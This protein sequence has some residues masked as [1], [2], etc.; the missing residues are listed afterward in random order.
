MWPNTLNEKRPALI[1]T[2]LI[3]LL[4]QLADE[5]LAAS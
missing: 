3:A 4:E 1:L 5:E 2:R